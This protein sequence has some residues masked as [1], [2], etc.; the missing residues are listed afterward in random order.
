MKKNIK[1]QICAK[2]RLLILH[3]SS[4][5]WALNT[6]IFIKHYLPNQDGVSDP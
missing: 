6:S 2:A 5:I 1:Q 3:T 4:G